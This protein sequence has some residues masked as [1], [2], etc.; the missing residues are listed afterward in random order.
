MC[1]VRLVLVGCLALVVT[2]CSSKP[3][4]PLIDTWEGTE[5]SVKGTYWAFSEN[6]NLDINL[7]PP[8]EL[9]LLEGGYKIAEQTQIELTFPN[10]KRAKWQGTYSF[11][12]AGDELTL[13]KEGET[14]V[15]KRSPKKFSVK[16]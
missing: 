11:K 14:L 10:F 5:G 9:A 4:N 3:Q 8:P 15:L 12:I 16:R 6:G 13:S 7:L 2:S 1:Q